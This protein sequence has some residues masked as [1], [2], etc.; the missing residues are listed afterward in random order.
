VPP[1]QERW[2]RARRRI[3]ADADEAAGGGSHK[4]VRQPRPSVLAITAQAAQERAQAQAQA[5]GWRSGGGRLGAM[6]EEAAAGVRSEQKRKKGLELRML[7]LRRT[8]SQ[9]TAEEEEQQ[10]AQQPRRPVVGV[11]R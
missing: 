3:A 10:V 8:I 2:Q 6:S 1:A 9:T 7:E 11:R 5:S 4:L